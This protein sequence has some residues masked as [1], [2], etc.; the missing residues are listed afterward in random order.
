[1]ILYDSLGLVPGF[2][3]RSNGI[4]ANLCLLHEHALVEKLAC[5]RPQPLH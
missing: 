2:L 1:M 4:A 3:R 5:L